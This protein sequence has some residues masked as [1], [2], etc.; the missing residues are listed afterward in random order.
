MKKKFITRISLT[1]FI[2]FGFFVFAGDTKSEE[3][4]SYEPAKVRLTGTIVRETFPGPPEYRSIEKGDAPEAFWILKLEKPVCVNGKVEDVDESETN[5][6][7]IQLVFD[8]GSDYN[9]YRPLLHKKVSVSG[10]LSHAFTVHHR[11]RVL[12]EVTGIKPVK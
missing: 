9:R 7:A 8:E 5:V 11:S 12:L 6:K 1:L 2:V 10:T 4:L 3:C